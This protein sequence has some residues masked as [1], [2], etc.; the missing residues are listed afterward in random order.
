MATWETLGTDP[1]SLLH[2]T[3]H[4]HANVLLRPIVAVGFNLTYQEFVDLIQPEPNESS[5]IR[6]KSVIQR[7]MPCVLAV[8]QKDVERL[9]RFLD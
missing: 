4:R 6:A 7:Y 1:L 5:Y 9:F 3:D 8:R 2:P